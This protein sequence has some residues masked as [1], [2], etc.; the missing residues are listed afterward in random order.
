MERPRQ[1]LRSHADSGSSPLGS[2][3][4]PV[5]R[6][7]LPTLGENTSYRHG[8]GRVPGI[9]P[10]L[11]GLL[12]S[13]GVGRDDKLLAARE[14]KCLS[15]LRAQQSHAINTRMMRRIERV[16]HV[17]KVNFRITLQ[18]RHALYSAREDLMKFGI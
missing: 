6:Q 12:R 5:T 18:E 16:R 7:D 9:S 15:I 14:L 10:L 11:L 8:G 1:C 4:T 13:L 2:V 17:L 3:P